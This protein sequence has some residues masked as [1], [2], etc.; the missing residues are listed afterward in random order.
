MQRCVELAYARRKQIHALL[1][2]ASQAAPEM[3]SF[4]DAPARTSF[5]CNCLMLSLFQVPV[6][7][8]TVDMSFGVGEREAL[9]FVLRTDPHFTWPTVSS[10]IRSES[11]ALTVSHI[12][13]SFAEV[14]C[15]FSAF[16]GCH[17]EIRLRPAVQVGA[18][19]QIRIDSH[20]A[21][22]PRWIALAA[23]ACRK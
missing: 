22:W 10:D 13:P 5:R 21:V 20:P 12:S 3:N 17:K 9:C 6:R 1:G 15:N 8:P 7:Q 16:I 4:C 23:C 18:A 2:G 14:G 19:T 11:V